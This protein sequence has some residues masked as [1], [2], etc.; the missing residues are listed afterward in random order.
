MPKELDQVAAA[1]KTAGFQWIV[2]VDNPDEDALRTA[3]EKFKDDY[4]F[5]E[6]NRLLFF[7]SGH[8]YTM[9]GWRRLLGAQRCP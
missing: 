4:G 2:R 3:F 6:N 9:G 5:N 7:F 1:L 8:G